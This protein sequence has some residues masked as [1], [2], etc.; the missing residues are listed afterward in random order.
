MNQTRAI[1]E[2]R[3]GSPDY[4]MTSLAGAGGDRRT[5]TEIQSINA[6]A[7]QS[8]DLRARL[9]RMSLGRLYKMTWSLLMQHDKGSLQYRFMEDSLMADPEALHDQYE[10]EPKGG[11]DMVSRAQMLQQAVNRKALFQNSPWIDQQ[12]LD[13]SILELD[14][15]SLVKRLI[16]AP[17]ARQQS[18]LEDEAKTIPTLLIGV[19][20]PAK[21]GQDY[22]GRIGVLVQWLNGAMQAGMQ[23]SPQAQQAYMQRIDSLLQAYEQVA[24]NEARKLRKEIQTY[25]VSIGLLP[26]PKAQPLPPVPQAQEVVA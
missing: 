22:A 3:I 12:E 7:M 25:L 15:P 16:V 26:D 5:A 20:V 18:E 6:Q 10:L 4:G 21:A 13:K 19:P 11:L 24:T 17:G 9:F 2:Q 14:D 23:L 8:G 1:A